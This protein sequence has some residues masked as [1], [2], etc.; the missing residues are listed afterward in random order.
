MTRAWC[1]TCDLVDHVNGHW[2]CL[3]CAT[4]TMG[5]GTR[6]RPRGAKFATVKVVK[7]AHRVHAEGAT[8]L[9]AARATITR[10]GY[11]DPRG[12]AMTL[13]GAWALLGLPTRSRSAAQT[14]RSKVNPAPLP[15][16]G[17]RYRHDVTTELL[18]ELY[19]EYRSTPQ[20]A[21][22]VG[23]SQQAVWERLSRAGVIPPSTRRKHPVTA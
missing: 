18:A 4:V 1:P 8:V 12:Y 9:D 11:M 19:A 20:I 16:R 17:P 2:Q 22:I 23:M 7:E 13:R 15:G 21:R 14:R 3:W 6:H 5:G 10:T